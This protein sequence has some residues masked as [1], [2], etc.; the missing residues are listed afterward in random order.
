MGPYRS[1]AKTRAVKLDWLK[2]L[3]AFVGEFG[4]TMPWFRHEWISCELGCCF[5]CLACGGMRVSESSWTSPRHPKRPPAWRGRLAR[6]TTFE[7]VVTTFGDVMKAVR[8]ELKSDGVLVD[9]DA[10]KLLIGLGVAFVLEA[11]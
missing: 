6:V 2:R 3:K 7:E 4:C 5:S 10:W 1:S 11:V 8:S 9:T